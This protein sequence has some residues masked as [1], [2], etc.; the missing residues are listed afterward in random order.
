MGVAP[1]VGP[2]DLAPAI[3]GSRRSSA[4]CLVRPLS[5]LVRTFPDNELSELFDGT[6][7]ALD[8]VYEGAFDRWVVP[9]SGGKDSTLTVILVS[10][11]LAAQERP[12]KLVVVYA[13]TLQELPQMRRTAESMLVFLQSIGRSAKLN[14]EAHTA[15]PALKDRFWVNLIGRGYPPPGPIFRWCTE[16]LKIWPT[17][18]YIDTGENTAVLTGVRLGESAH[19]TGRLVASCRTGGECG[20]DVW[21]RQESPGSCVSYF[22]PILKWRTCKVWDFLHLV[23]PDAGW[24]TG[25]VYELYGGTTLRFGCWNCSLVTRDRA[26]ESLIAK[27][28]GSG[29]STLNALRESIIIGAKDPRNRLMRN[30]HLGP[31]SMEF[32]HSLLDRLLDAEAST[33]LVLITSD[34]VAE[35]R[36]LWEVLGPS[37][38]KLKRAVS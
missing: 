2:L 15:I 4:G 21:M 27:E 36:R 1:L 31:L 30:G 14:L 18:P 13:D 37:V 34:E 9:F 11:Y 32:R 6:R 10:D 3:L 23:A 19:R 22:A 28:P 20:Q 5:K 29:L 24:P 8:R 7:R 33:G 25:D 12:P 38:S 17:K 26:A 16:R 35:I